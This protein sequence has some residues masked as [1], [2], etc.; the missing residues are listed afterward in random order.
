MC[1]VFLFQDWDVVIDIN[2]KSDLFELLTNKQA[3]DDNVVIIPEE[4][5][6]IHLSGMAQVAEYRREHTFCSVCKN[7]INV[8]HINISN[9]ATST[10]LQSQGAAYS[11]YAWLFSV[12][13]ES[14]LQVTSSKT[15]NW[16]VYI[17]GCV[18]VKQTKNNVFHC[19]HENDICLQ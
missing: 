1:S 17:T 18:Q 15:I 9:L 10:W 16:H 12:Y 7:T 6:F 8:K 19:T 14:L 13:Q 11:H 4:Q 5:V 2:I 3:K